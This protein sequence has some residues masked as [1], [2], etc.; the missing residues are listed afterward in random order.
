MSFLGIRLTH[1][2]QHFENLY[3]KITFPKSIQDQSGMVPGSLRHQKNI[4]L[5]AWE[6]SRIIK[7]IK[8]ITKVINSRIDKENEGIGG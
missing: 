3:E 4:N 1:V 7:N 8:K 6:D 2:G 5:N